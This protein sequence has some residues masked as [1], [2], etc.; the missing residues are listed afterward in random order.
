ME[1][2]VQR[3]ALTDALATRLGTH[4]DL[5][6]SQLFDISARLNMFQPIIPIPVQAPPGFEQRA[7][8]IGQPDAE[9][10]PEK[11]DAPNELQQRQQ[12]HTILRRENTNDEKEEN[13]DNAG[14]GRSVRVKLFNL[15]DGERTDGT[16]QTEATDKVSKKK[17]G[18]EEEEEE[19]EEHDEDEEDE[20]HPAE[21]DVSEQVEAKNDLEQYCFTMRKTL[22]EGN[23]KDQLEANSMNKI[24]TAVQEMFDWL[25]KQFLAEEDAFE[26]KRKEREGILKLIRVKADQMEAKCGLSHAAFVIQSAF[27]R[28]RAR[29]R[30]KMLDNNMKLMRLIQSNFDKIDQ[31]VAS[32]DALATEYGTV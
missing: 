28:H 7:M 14:N 11:D 24:E 25:D 5:V 12:Q 27:R 20:K 31:F 13:E 30:D 3:S 6:E 10:S 23:V 17:E 1:A 15:Y 16:T 32:V 19:H 2:K 9:R 26:G 8:A 29:E 22:Q 18:E 4:M 21:D